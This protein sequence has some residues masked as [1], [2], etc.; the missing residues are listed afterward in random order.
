M[1][2][3]IV[4]NSQDALPSK[5]D[6]LVIWEVIIIHFAVGKFVTTLLEKGRMVVTNL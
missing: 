5:K 4:D 6:H 1:P 2:E 3:G